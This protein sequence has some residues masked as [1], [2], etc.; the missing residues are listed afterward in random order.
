MTPDTG[1][2]SLR[3]V[4]TWALQA[5]G[6]LLVSV[7]TQKGLAQDKEQ[8]NLLPAPR[9]RS[10][11]WARAV[12]N[13]ARPDLPS[14]HHPGLESRE[15]CEIAGP[16]TRSACARNALFVTQRL[17]HMPSR[18]TSQDLHHLSK[19]VQPMCPTATLARRQQQSAN[20][21]GRLQHKLCV[22]PLS[23]VCRSS[24]LQQPEV[25]PRHFRGA[26]PIEALGLSLVT[27]SLR[28][29][30]RGKPGGPNS[31]RCR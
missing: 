19:D 3:F 30:R 1:L 18:R 13:Q 20:D 6:F 5:L 28:R 14:H 21:W 4:S 8:G 29:R 23:L 25:P 2:G 9:R 24:R 22:S 11:S 12:L 7:Q 26:A 10:S 31:S 17:N 16:F 27:F 15:N